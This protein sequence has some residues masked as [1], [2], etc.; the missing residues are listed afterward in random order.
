MAL[1]NRD[2]NG[3]IDTV[4][5]MSDASYL[6]ISSSLIRDSACLGG[7]VSQLVPTNVYQALL[8]KYPSA[9]S[10]QK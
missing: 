10:V 8:K 9:D 4:F 6:Y 7:N 5:L 2:L 3:G 1:L